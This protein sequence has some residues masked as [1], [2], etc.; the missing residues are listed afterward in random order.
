MSR[1]VGASLF[2]FGGYYPTQFHR[3]PITSLQNIFRTGDFISYFRAGTT[4]VHNIQAEVLLFQ[5]TA[6]T[7]SGSWSIELG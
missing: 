2:S 7:S 6:G 4:I 5:A 3:T 1:L